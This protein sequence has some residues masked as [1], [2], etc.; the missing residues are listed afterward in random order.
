[1]CAL[2]LYLKYLSAVGLK[3]DITEE[4]W[5]VTLDYTHLISNI[6]VLWSYLCYVHFAITW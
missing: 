5:N 6:R 1:M 2:G 3:V 4:T